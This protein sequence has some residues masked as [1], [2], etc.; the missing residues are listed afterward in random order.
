MLLDPAVERR[1]FD[2]EVGLLAK[3]AARLRALGAVVVRAE[4]PEIDVL[5]VPHL[6]VRVGLPVAPLSSGPIP[7]GGQAYQA[8]D[9][10]G[11]AGSAFGV[12]VDLRGYDQQA[13][14]ITFRDPLTWE[15]AP[16][17]LLPR[18]QIIDDPTKPRLVLLD[19]HPTAKRPFLCIR[20]VRE[21]HEHPQ[22]N[23]EDWA[24]Y[25]DGTNVYVLVERIALMT[26]VWVRPMIT[27]ASGPPGQMQLMLQWT[28]EVGT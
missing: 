12:R 22:H 9:F 11:S 21:Y 13:P 8:F 27:F 25:R 10:P 19:A 6:P 16:Y 20:G 3:N 28:A 5:C 15:L 1:K 18:A 14:S 23:G 2:R 4:R 24:M 17:D 7:P 26:M